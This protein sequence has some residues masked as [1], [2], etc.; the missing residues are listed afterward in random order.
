MFNRLPD[1]SVLLISSAYVAMTVGTV[2]N[3]NAA[4]R[5]KFSRVIKNTLYVD[6]YHRAQL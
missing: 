4:A 5:T 6:S 3:P 1:T 2:V